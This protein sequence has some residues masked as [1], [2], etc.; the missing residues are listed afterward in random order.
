MDFIVAH[1][2]YFQPFVENDEKFDDYVADMRKE[3]IWGGN[4]E[5]QAFSMLF[6]VNVV[7]H[8]LNQPAY[9]F[10]VPAPRRAVHLSYHQG[11]HYNSVR[12]END[13]NDNPPRELPTYLQELPIPEVPA[14]AKGHEKDEEEKKS[15]GNKDSLRRGGNWSADKEEEKVPSSDCSKKKSADKGDLGFEAYLFPVTVGVGGDK[16]RYDATG[17][18]GPRCSGQDLARG[19]QRSRSHD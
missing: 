15:G 6:S 10:T 18:V 4:M 19:V 11:Q 5:I 14:V 9:V 3:A 16:L 8:M 2:E 1:R 17:C 12:W 13:L 7:V